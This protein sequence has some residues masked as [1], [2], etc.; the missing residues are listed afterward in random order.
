MLLP[1]PAHFPFR[2]VS[3]FPRR[4]FPQ[5]QRGQNSAR[6]YPSGLPVI[7]GRYAF[8]LS[9]FLSFKPALP[10]AAKK[11]YSDCFQPPPQCASL[12]FHPRFFVP[13]LLRMS[14]GLQQP[15]SIPCEALNVSQMEREGGNDTTRLSLSLQSAREAEMTTTFAAKA[16]ARKRVLHKIWICSTGVKFNRHRTALTSWCMISGGEFEWK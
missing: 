11:N 9:F 4:H 6:L 15:A 13:C 7:P 16:E 2:H 8:F 5:R 10:S 14:I 12:P 3:A 1:L